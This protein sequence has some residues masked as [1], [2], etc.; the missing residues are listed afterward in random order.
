MV[1]RGEEFLGVASVPV[2]DVGVKC[3]PSIFQG[4]AIGFLMLTKGQL[5][6]SEPS[7]SELAF[8]CTASCFKCSEFLCVPGSGACKL[9]LTRLNRSMNVKNTAQEGVVI[10]H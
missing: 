10:L 5:V 3:R 4:L 2:N 1:Y 7:V 9:D 6:N 8:Q